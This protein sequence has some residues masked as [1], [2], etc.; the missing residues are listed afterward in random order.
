MRDKMV[1]QKKFGVQ[2]VGLGLVRDMLDNLPKHLTRSFAEQ[3]REM[4][5]NVVRE[6]KRIVPV[7]TGLLKS[8]IFVREHSL[9]VFEIV[10]AT[11]YAGFVEYGTINMVARPYI[12]PALYR[13]STTWSKKILDRFERKLRGYYG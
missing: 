10:A 12:R 8:Q 5:I 9:E 6:A 11:F 2:V 13:Y 7:D 4:A 3:T 1:V